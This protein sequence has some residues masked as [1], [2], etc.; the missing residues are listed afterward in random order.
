MK[1]KQIIDQIRKNS[2]K[3]NALREVNKKLERQ[4]LLL[5]DKQ[6]QYVE[7]EETVGRGKNKRTHLI[8]RVHWKEYFMDE[9]T[10]QSILINRSRIV[11]QDG[12]WINGY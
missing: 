4:H 8:G 1:R 3:I 5:S 7:K 11:R 10:R 9:D 2:A 12:E 6:Q